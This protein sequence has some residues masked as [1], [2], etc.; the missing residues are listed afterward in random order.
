MSLI[1]THF[2]D[3]IE[4]STDPDDDDD[5]GNEPDLTPEESRSPRINTDATLFG[6]PIVDSILR[7]L[8]VMVTDANR[9]LIDVDYLYDSQGRPDIGLTV[10]STHT[11]RILLEPHLSKLQ[12]LVSPNEDPKWYLDFDNWQ[13]SRQI[14]KQASKHEGV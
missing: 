3:A 12:A 5:D 10:G 9:S 8:D 6:L 2:A 13:W 7:Y 14:P 4:Y 1:H 11:G